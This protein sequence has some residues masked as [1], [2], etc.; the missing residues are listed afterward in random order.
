MGEESEQNEEIPPLPSPLVCS[1]QLSPSGFIEKTHKWPISA[2]SRVIE[3]MRVKTTRHL[4][5]P[6]RMFGR[7][8]TGHAQRGGGCG[9]HG[10]LNGGGRGCDGDATVPQFLKN[11]PSIYP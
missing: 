11:L 10:G 5:T 2:A 6:L 1:R 8:K 9:G 3:K 4:C 7:K